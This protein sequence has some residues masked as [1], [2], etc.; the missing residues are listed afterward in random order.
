M[1]HIFIFCYCWNPS[2]CSDESD[3]VVEQQ[4]VR[5]VVKKSLESLWK[6]VCSKYVAGIKFHLVH[7][8]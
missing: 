7:I 2:Y 6:L 1:K 4:A 5:Q 8:R 3:D